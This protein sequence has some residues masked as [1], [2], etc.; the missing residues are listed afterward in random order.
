MEI[1]FKTNNIEKTTPQFEK[2]VELLKYYS[3]KHIDEKETELTIYENNVSEVYYD[4]LFET[5]NIV[6]TIGQ[7]MKH[8]QNI[9]APLK[10]NDSIVEE[11]YKGFEKYCNAEIS[12][13]PDIE[14][15]YKLKAFTIKTENA[16]TD[17]ITE[18]LENYWCQL[19]KP[20]MPLNCQS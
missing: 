18:I 14:S 7:F 15:S 11:M 20:L 4:A 19:L 1:T 2:C 17:E 5:E 16:V 8:F 10:L 12:G 9:I 3:D 6:K 13:V